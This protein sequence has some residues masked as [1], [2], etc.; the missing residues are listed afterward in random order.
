M[1]LVMLLLLLEEFF[2]LA[3]I[4]PLRVLIGDRKPY[5]ASPSPGSN[6]PS[7]R[8][9]V[10]HDASLQS[11][12][13]IIITKQVLPILRQVFAICPD[14][15]V[16]LR[17]RP[18]HNLIATHYR[19]SEIHASHDPLPPAWEWHPKAA[20]HG[21][22]QTFVSLRKLPQKR[23]QRGHVNV[24]DARMG[25]KDTSRTEMMAI[26]FEQYRLRIRREI[27]N[28]FKRKFSRNAWNEV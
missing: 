10:P 20:V 16:R 11:H 21:L 12:R 9:T 26:S 5:A 23:E 18:L 4:L 7:I 19:Q 2:K 1:L 8:S 27:W 24:K 6:S 14:A 17:Y 15:L 3:S 13:V 28:R 22:L 25:I